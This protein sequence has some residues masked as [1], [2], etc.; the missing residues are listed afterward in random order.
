MLGGAGMGV[1]ILVGTVGAKSGRVRTVQ[2]AAFEDASRVKGKWLVVGSR[3]GDAI[4]PYWLTN[5]RVLVQAS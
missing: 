4:H 3:G 2:L 5:M 1:M